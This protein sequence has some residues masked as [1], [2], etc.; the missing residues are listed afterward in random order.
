MYRQM[1]PHRQGTVLLKVG[2]Q[3]KALTPS[4]SQYTGKSWGQNQSPKLQMWR[5]I[6]TYKSCAYACRPVHTQIHKLGHTHKKRK[7]NILREWERETNMEKAQWESVEMHAP[8]LSQSV[9]HTDKKEQARAS[10]LLVKHW[11][12]QCGTCH[13]RLLPGDDSIQSPS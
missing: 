2:L 12:E 3:N 6:E 11:Y 9:R 8:L 1:W 13:L 5:D 4:W 7:V 10:G